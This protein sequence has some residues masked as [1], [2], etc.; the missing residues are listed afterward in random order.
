MTRVT[1]A[2]FRSGRCRLRAVGEFDRDCCDQFEAA[3]RVALACYCREI[4]VDLA[5]VTFVDAATVGALLAC[6]ESA[7]T[8]GCD[9][10]IVNDSGVAARVL[11][12]SGARHRLLSPSSPAGQQ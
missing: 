7:A 9:L 4:V 11:E 1:L 2:E 3:T 10:W 5:E 6:H 12:I 8:H